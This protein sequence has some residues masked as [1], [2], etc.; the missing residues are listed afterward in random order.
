MV[1]GNLHVVVFFVNG[2]WSKP[3]RARVLL[4]RK[5]STVGCQ[6]RVTAAL[7]AQDHGMV[8]C[9]FPKSIS[10]PGMIP[11][12]FLPL[13]CAKKPESSESSG[14]SMTNGTDPLRR[15]GGG[16]TER[17]MEERCWRGARDRQAEET[18][19]IHSPQ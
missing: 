4:P 11:L 1:G 18:A 5:L 8:I 3:P 17:G 9:A 10:S 13:Q 6:S 2:H 15:D 16:E 19:A 12:P 7:D 14:T